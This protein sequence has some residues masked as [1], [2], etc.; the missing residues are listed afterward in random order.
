MLHPDRE[1]AKD[2]GLRSSEPLTL[3]QKRLGGLLMKIETFRF[4]WLDVDQE[5][6][7]RFPEGLVG[8]SRL[9]RFV[10][11][12]DDGASDLYWLQS[13]DQGEFALALV[14]NAKLQS[15][16]AFDG[17]DVDLSALQLDHPEDAEILLVLNRVDGD[18][19]ANLKGPIVINP[20]KSLGKQVVLRDARFDVRHPLRAAKPA[21]VTA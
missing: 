21:L 10:L 20:A 15:P 1:V 18:F 6:V 17:E 5:D 7:I 3:F 16:V 13:L 9:T 4:G 8:L 11:V 14:T 12:H 19:T 2:D